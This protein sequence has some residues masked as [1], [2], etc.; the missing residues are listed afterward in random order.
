MLA[1][2]CPYCESYN[3]RRIH[4]GLIRKIVFQVKHRYQCR[5]CYKKF[6]NNEMSNHQKSKKAE[7]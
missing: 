7:L 4:R 5:E 2:H 1:K 6:T 3:L